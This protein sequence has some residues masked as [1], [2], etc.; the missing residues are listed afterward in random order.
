MCIIKI[1]FR[2]SI[3]NVNIKNEQ[4]IYPEFKIRPNGRTHTEIPH[5]SNYKDAILER[6]G[7]GLEPF[8]STQ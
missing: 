8:S 6:I 2:K 7:S 5:D 3:P 1:S 4:L